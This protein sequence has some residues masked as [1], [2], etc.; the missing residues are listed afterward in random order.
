[1]RNPSLGIIIRPV[2]GWLNSRIR[3]EAEAESAKMQSAVMVT[4]L[5]SANR[6]KLIKM[7]VSQKTSTT[8]NGAGIAP[9]ALAKSSKRVFPISVV[10][11]IAL[12]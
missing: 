12:A 10:A 5:I 3:S 8:R 9:P 7:M 4:A 6:L 11:S 1:M 2:N